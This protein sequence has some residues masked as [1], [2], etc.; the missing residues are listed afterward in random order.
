[1]RKKSLPTRVDLVKVH[2]APENDMTGRMF[3]EWT[4][5][6]YVGSRQGPWFRCQCSCGYIGV[7]KGL[8][9]RR[10]SMSCGHNGSTYKHGLARRDHNRR[11]PEYSVWV[12]M[13]VRCNDP[14][15]LSYPDYGGRGVRVCQR[16]DDFDLFL[17][18][19]GCR[20][21]AGMT[22]ERIDNNGNYEP[23]NCRWATRAEQRRNSKGL[24]LHTRDGF[25]LCLKDWCVKLGL[26][27][28]RIY[29]RV[30]RG[31]S[32]KDALIGKEV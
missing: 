26:D 1:M 11:P 8:E 5:L 29:G 28:G 16:W 30:R 22:I 15:S 9:L 10:G 3:G 24:I 19:M 18:D 20:P 12:G 21:N 17:A 32:V 2:L 4:V 14:D 31:W 7:V 27:Y 25:T 6:N 13:R 23:S